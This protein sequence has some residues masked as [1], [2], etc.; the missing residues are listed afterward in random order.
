VY[1]Q[2]GESWREKEYALTVSTGGSI[3]SRNSRAALLAPAVVAVGRP[4]TIH[5]YI[6]ATTIC[7]PTIV[8][9]YHRMRR[10]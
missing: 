1:N 3:T 9:M 2:K 8:K 10:G 7:V 4:L 6:S 5:A